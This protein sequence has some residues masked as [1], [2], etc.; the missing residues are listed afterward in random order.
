MK[1]SF[2]FYPISKSEFIRYSSDNILSLLIDRNGNL[3]GGTQGGGLIKFDMKTKNFEVYRYNSMI[4]TS[5]LPGYLHNIFE[6][7]SG[8]IWL[9]VFQGGVTRIDQSLN[10]IEQYY[11]GTKNSNGIDEE[12]IRCFYEADDGKICVTNQNCFY[13]TIHP[14][15]PILDKIILVKLYHKWAL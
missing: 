12:K 13:L 5:I 15:F 4:S 3:W 1:K 11:Y 9:P 2:T 8:T 6:D 7:N 14:S 10:Q